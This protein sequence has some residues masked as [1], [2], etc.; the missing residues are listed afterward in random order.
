[1]FWQVYQDE[2]ISATRHSSGLP[3]PICTAQG[4]KTITK[5]CKR[6]RKSIVVI[7]KS[8]KLSTS[9]A[10]IRFLLFFYELSVFKHC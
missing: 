10:F 1:M 7:I 5:Y 8:R 4:K 6:K 9:N 2:K 3:G